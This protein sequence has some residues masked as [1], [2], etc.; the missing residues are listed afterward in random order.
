MAGT[1][2][3]PSAPLSSCH[4]DYFRTATAFPGWWFG[5]TGYIEYSIRDCC[6]HP[7]EFWLS[8]QWSG[9][10]LRL[11]MSPAQSPVRD[12]WEVP[13]PLTKGAPVLSPQKAPLHG[14]GPHCPP[15][16]ASQGS[17]GLEPGGQSSVTS[18]PSLPKESLNALMW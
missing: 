14:L 11:T 17:P 12:D 13:P 16:A 8:R 1:R 6:H 7:P 2:S 5:L 10:E 18:E 4:L 9:E 15:R 3:L